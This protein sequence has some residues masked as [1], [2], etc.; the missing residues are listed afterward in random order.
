V[1]VFR[2]VAER[3]RIERERAELLAREQEARRDAEDANRTKDDFLAMLSHELRTPLT[4]IVG[5][6]RMLRV[7]TLDAAARDR[8]LEVIERNANVQTRLVNDML[9]ISRFMRGQI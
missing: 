4:S 3:R 5:W 9:D 8:A 7:A 2:D 6:A 1:I